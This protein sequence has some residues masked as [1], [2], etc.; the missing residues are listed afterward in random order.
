MCKT[1]TKQVHEVTEADYQVSD[2][3]FVE[4]MFE[5]KRSPNH[6]FVEI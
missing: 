4:T 3:F 5:D 2:S 6:V 1:S